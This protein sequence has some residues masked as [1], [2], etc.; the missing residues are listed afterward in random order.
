MI[1]RLQIPQIKRERLFGPIP[2][3]KSRL[4][5]SVGIKKVMFADLGL[6]ACWK[7][8]GLNIGICGVFLEEAEWLFVSPFGQMPLSAAEDPSA[9]LCA[10]LGICGEKSF[11]CSFKR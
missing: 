7:D 5:K 8:A 2:A 3:M 11:C 9:K 10:E 6:W 1:R 4:H